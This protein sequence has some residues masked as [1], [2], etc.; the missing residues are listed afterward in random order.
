MNSVIDPGRASVPRWLTVEFLPTM[1]EVHRFA[2]DVDSAWAFYA[3]QR[4]E[5]ADAFRL[6]LRDLAPSI[7]NYNNALREFRVR[8]D[9]MR[10][11]LTALSMQDVRLGVAAATVF[12]YA[13]S[14]FQPFPELP[15]F[16]P[17]GSVDKQRNDLL[18]AWHANATQF[19]PRVEQ[20]KSH[21]RDL[22]CEVLRRA[23]VA[24]SDCAG[25]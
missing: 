22:Q 21:L 24:T 19:R 9:D 13:A 6:Q 16:D 12:D 23:R 8:Q 17:Q 11:Q 2:D 4:L 18:S 3:H 20:L 14:K 15:R 25:S 7:A 1:R 5:S 10:A